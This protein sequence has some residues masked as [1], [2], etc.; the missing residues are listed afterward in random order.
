MENTIDSP[1][2]DIRQKIG[3]IEVVELS[4]LGFVLWGLWQPS[5]RQS[6]T[7]D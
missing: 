4:I 5:S 3:L 2:H 7:A 1:M 6:L